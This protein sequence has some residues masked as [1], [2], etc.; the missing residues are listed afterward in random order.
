MHWQVFDK[1]HPQV[2]LPVHPPLTSLRSFA[3][4]LRWGEGGVRSSHRQG[5]RDCSHRRDVI[6]EYGAGP[7]FFLVGLGYSDPVGVDAGFG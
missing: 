5:G 6:D 3:P 2:W 4:P 1:R 7:G